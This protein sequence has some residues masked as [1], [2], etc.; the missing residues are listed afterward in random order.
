MNANEFEYHLDPPPLYPRS[1]SVSRL[2]ATTA[3][4]ASGFGYGG[5]SSYAERH[6]PDRKKT[7]E[8]LEKMAKAQLKRDRKEKQRNEKKR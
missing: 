2:L 4:L 7:V 5:H 6:D 3:L 8:D 1:K